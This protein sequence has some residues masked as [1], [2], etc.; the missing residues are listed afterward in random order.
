[1]V[2]EPLISNV[3]KY[4]TDFFAVVTH[5][6]VSE[7]NTPPCKQETFVHI[8]RHC[9]L[10][11]QFHRCHF[12]RNKGGRN[13]VCCM[14]INV[15]SEFRNV[16]FLDMKKIIDISGKMLEFQNAFYY[17]WLQLCWTFEWSNSVGFR[18]AF[19]ERR[20]V[21]L[22][23]KQLLSQVQTHYT[24]QAIQ[25]VYV[26]IFGLDV[27]GNPYGLIKDFT[28]GL[29]DLF[30]EPFLVGCLILWIKNVHSMWKEC[31]CYWVNYAWILSCFVFSNLRL[32]SQSSCSLKASPKAWFTLLLSVKAA[33]NQDSSPI[34]ITS[35]K[36]S[37]HAF[38]LLSRGLSKDRM[39]L[40]I[41]WSEEFTVC[42]V[43]LLVRIPYIYSFW[44]TVTSLYNF[45][46]KSSYI[47]IKIY[48]SVYLGGN[49]LIHF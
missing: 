28:Q 29:G 4:L 30:Y 13:E 10:L 8:W 41:V 44:P 17:P 38:V 25:Q 11:P 46:E 6:P 47:W 27:L 2:D 37:M 49:G 34:I 19:F 48:T 1:M 42:S 20:G 36:W 7:W 3:L 31:F 39:S 12:H 9:R 45:T 35:W 32:N 16:F 21:M 23:T 22:S 14:Y 15:L 43:T 18:M 5:Q 24:H 40:L 33:I 26:L